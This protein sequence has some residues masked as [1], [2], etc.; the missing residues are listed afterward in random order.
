MFPRFTYCVIHLCTAGLIATV[1]A[2][3]VSQLE[4]TFFNS[5]FNLQSPTKMAKFF[6]ENSVFWDTFMDYCSHLVESY[7]KLQCMREVRKYFLASKSLLPT[8]ASI[9]LFISGRFWSNHQWNHIDK[10]R[11]NS[12]VKTAR[13]SLPLLGLLSQI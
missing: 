3:F 8:F 12:W 4:T 9:N 6:S 7:S 2:V 1:V 11:T 10:D 5:N 13:S